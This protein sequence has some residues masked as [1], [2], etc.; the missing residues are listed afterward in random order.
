MYAIRCTRNTGEVTILSSRFRTEDKANAA[1]SKLRCLD[2]MRGQR[3]VFEYEII[4]IGNSAEI[5]NKKQ[6]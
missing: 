4:K 5:T 3:N 1:C 6:H 2:V